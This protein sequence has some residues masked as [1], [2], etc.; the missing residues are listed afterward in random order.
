MKNLLWNM[1]ANIQNGQLAKRS[2]VIQKRKKICEYILN[3][4]W[5]E[6]FI[7]G[8]KLVKNDVTQLKIFLK[9]DNGK[10]VIKTLKPISKPGLR[11]YY[12][13]K[14]IWKIDTS[15]TFIVIS[16]NKGVKTIIDCKKLK[17]G[18]EPFIII[19]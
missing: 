16:T 3:V 9:Y 7:L 5:N 18:G 11:I 13:L 1:F 12:S 2:F 19:N 17:L 15:K 10:P 6:G 4:L 8:Y 14:Q